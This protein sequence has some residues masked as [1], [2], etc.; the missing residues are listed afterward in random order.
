LA[1]PAAPAPARHQPAVQAGILAFAVLLCAASIWVGYSSRGRNHDSDSFSATESRP[2]VED[3]VVHESFSIIDNTRED[4]EGLR[5]LLQFDI[6]TRM[7]KLQKLTARPGASP[8]AAKAMLDRIIADLEDAMEDFHGTGEEL[9][10]V[11]DLFRAL[12]QAGQP[13][14]WVDLYLTILYEHPTHSVVGEFS[15]DA[16]AMGRS[17]GREQ[18]IIS[19]L[20]HLTNI[21]LTFVGKARVE[22]ALVTEKAKGSLLSANL[23]EDP[24]NQ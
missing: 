9:N 8:V 24:S 13:G 16:L 22:N 4:L 20:S 3:L 5:E 12:K 6:K 15:G 2:R 19:G 14:R 17:T 11:G 7:V 1:A 18:E 10:L 23:A 21:P